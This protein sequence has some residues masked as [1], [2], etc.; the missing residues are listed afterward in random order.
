MDEVFSTDFDEATVND[1]TDPV[2]SDARLHMG[3]VKGVGGGHRLCS[4]LQY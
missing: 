1:E 3:S 2:N 4:P